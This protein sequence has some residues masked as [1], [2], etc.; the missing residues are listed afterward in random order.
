MTE[1]IN[2]GATS[3]SRS[4]ML[5]TISA[6]IILLVAGGIFIAI[7]SAGSQDSAELQAAPVD[8]D[9]DLLSDEDERTFKTDASKPDT[10]GDGLSDYL[11]VRNFKTDPLNP[12]SKNPKLLDGEWVMQ[13]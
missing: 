1:E 6:I 8:S 3:K 9:Q 2:N 12:R 13:P 5:L 10:D 4:I 11:E 7:R